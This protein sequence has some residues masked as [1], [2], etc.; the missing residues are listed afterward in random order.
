MAYTTAN[1]VTEAK[2]VEYHGPAAGSA[3]YRL[4][5][6]LRRAERLVKDLAPPPEGMSAEEAVTYSVV[7]ADAELAVFEWFWERPDYLER[8]KIG[9]VDVKYRDASA[10]ED[11]VRREMGRYY[12]GP[13]EVAPRQNLS[14]SATVKNISDQPL[15]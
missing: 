9:D 5:T 1:G 10:V 3:A 14:P 2:A 11:L 12:I 6:T 4:D 8:D 13:R 7:A 15:W